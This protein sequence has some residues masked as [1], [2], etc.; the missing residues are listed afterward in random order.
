MRPGFNTSQNITMHQSRGLSPTYSGV[1]FNTA[2]PT[3]TCPYHLGEPVKRVC[4]YPS[5]QGKILVCSECVYE[6]P[7]HLKLHQNYIITLNDFLNK[8]DEQS[9]VKKSKKIFEGSPARSSVQ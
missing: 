4:T 6:D 7:D 8:L 3:I 2:I 1:I 9:K 5:C